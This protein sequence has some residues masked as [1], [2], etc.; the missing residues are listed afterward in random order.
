LEKWGGDVYVA[1]RGYN[2]GSV[3]LGELN[4]SMGATADYVQKIANRL[5]GHTWPGM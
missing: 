2:S 1:L 4:D 3:N 5:M